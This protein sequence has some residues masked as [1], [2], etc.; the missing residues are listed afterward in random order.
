MPVAT[1]DGLMLKIKRYSDRCDVVDL[2]CGRRELSIH[3]H[4]SPI[5]ASDIDEALNLTGSS[6]DHYRGI[7]ALESQDR[8]CHRG[9]S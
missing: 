6:S 3:G 4:F 7:T 9:G 2:H 5:A 1:S 8:Y